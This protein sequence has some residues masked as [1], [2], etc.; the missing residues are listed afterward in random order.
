MRVDNA[1]IYPIAGF[2][3]KLVEA[4]LT[5]GQHHR[6]RLA[7]DP[8]SIHVDVVEVI[9]GPNR[10]S[11]LESRLQR[12]PVPESNVIERRGILHRIKDGVRDS[13]FKGRLLDSVEAESFAGE[14]DVVPNVWCF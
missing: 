2:G 8:I 1:C 9:V 13:W 14:I 5:C 6:R 3:W 11:L 12:A 7:S 4:E 10:L